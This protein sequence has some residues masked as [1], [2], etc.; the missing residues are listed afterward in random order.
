M[1][2]LY[3]ARHA[4]SS[5]D[6]SSLSDIDRPLNNRGKKNAPQMGDRMAARGVH[7]DYMI[8]SPANRARS[9][10]EYLAAALNYDIRTIDTNDLIYF[11]GS[12]SILDVIRQTPESIKSLMVVGHNPDMTS[13]CHYLCDFGGMDMPTCAIASLEYDGHWSE[14]DANSAELADYDFPKNQQ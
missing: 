6:N 12:S 13:L 14:L 2:K 11:E 1:K 10:A 8:S 5:W 7:L 9:T 4:K 3:L